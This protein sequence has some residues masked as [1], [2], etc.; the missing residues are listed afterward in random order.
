[1]IAKLKRL[2]SAVCTA[3]H[4]PERKAC[5]LTTLTRPSMSSAPSM[6]QLVTE[7]TKLDPPVMLDPIISTLGVYYQLPRCP[8]P[9]DLDPDSNGSPSD[10]LIVVMRPVNTINNKCARTVRQV[11]VRPLPQSGLDKVKTWMEN[12]NWSDVL[13]EENVDKKAK[14]LHQMVLNQLNLKNKKSIK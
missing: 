10:N 12:Q 7:Y 2:L 13:L 11:T 5:F 3:N 1:M 9:L 14:T 8:P 6:R 4:H